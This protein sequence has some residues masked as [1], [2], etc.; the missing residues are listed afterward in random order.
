M[1]IGTRGRISLNKKSMNI[2]DIGIDVY[3]T[4]TSVSVFLSR[5]LSRLD[6]ICAASRLREAVL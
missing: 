1:D 6:I 5:G 3:V 4:T 2:W